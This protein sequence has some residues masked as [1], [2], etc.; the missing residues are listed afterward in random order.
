MI[1]NQTGWGLPRC[2]YC[3]KKLGFWEAWLMR[4][5]GEY[6]CPKCGR[7][8]NIK[9]Q[10]TTYGMAAIVS[11]LGLGILLVSTLLIQN[12]SLWGIPFVVLPFLLFVF[13]S[14]CWMFLEAFQP[15][16]TGTP[17][18][19]NIPAGKAPYQANSQASGSMPAPP[20][21]RA[22]QEAFSSGHTQVVP[23]LGGKS[24]ANPAG[25]HSQQGRPA[26]TRT[27]FPRQGGVRPPVMRQ[28]PPVRNAAP[29]RPFVPPQRKQPAPPP[30]HPARDNREGQ[31][32]V[33]RPPRS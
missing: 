3:G 1:M 30:A 28:T 32:G 5:K 24:P 26:G 15:A 16:G 8:S 19:R 4:T 12:R 22:E 17:L 31:D 20:V 23:P 29:E 9:F 33:G 2:P 7:A 10:K 14:P 18:G 21:R 6:T 25:R 27:Y 11:I 13:L